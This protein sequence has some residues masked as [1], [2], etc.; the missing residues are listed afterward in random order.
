MPPKAAAKAVVDKT[1]GLKNKNKS[2]KVQAF[3]QRTEQA[4][5]RAGK[6]PAQ[7]KKEEEAKKERDA[8]RAMKGQKT[9]I[10]ILL[11]PVVKKTIVPP[12]VDPKTMIC[13]YF[14]A[15]ACKNGNKCKFSHDLEVERKKDK[16]NL[17]VDPREADTMDSWDQAKLEDVVKSK[18]QERPNAT[19]IVCK[20]FIEAIEAKKYG[21]FWSCP[22]GEDCIYQ[23]KL[24]PGFVLKSEM[25]KEEDDGPSIEDQIEV[26]RKL[27]DR[28]KGTMVTPETFKAW[29][30]KKKAEKQAELFQTAKEAQKKVGGRSHGGLS[31]RALFAYDPTLFI[32][33]ADA[34]GDD[35]YEI[36]SN[37]EE[38]EQKTE[39]TEDAGPNDSDADGDDSAE[40]QVHVTAVDESL[41]L[42][43]AD[44]PSDEDE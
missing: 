24:P 41:F 1:F 9:E 8:K 6:T 23:H 14:K 22:S 25:K 43:D 18:E 2:K 21:W 37:Y 11:A 33:D 10:E 17:Y 31:G 40:V 35:A 42:E 3:V 28:T 29:K 38:E 7:L 44:L 32:D 15:G 34:A 26:E 39:K 4:A 19:K 13:E 36:D 12:G 27:L 16:I 5:Q 30:E 20:Y